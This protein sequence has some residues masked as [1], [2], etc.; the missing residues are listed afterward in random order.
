MRSSNTELQSSEKR[1]TSGEK[2]RESDFQT[3]CVGLI[4]VKHF[5]RIIA[6]PFPKGIKFSQLQNG[7]GTIFIQPIRVTINILLVKSQ[8]SGVLHQRLSF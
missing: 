6:A 2:R 4:A 5:A 3:P 8:F 1:K 7:L